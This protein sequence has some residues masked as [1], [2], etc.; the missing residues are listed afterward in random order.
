MIITSTTTVD[1]NHLNAFI[2][3]CKEYDREPGEET[4]H[5]GTGDLEGTT[6]SV[7]RISTLQGNGLLVTVGNDDEVFLVCRLIA[8]PV[9]QGALPWL[10]L[11]HI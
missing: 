11:I 7:K 2:A 8:A 6:I 1:N 4:K 3:D 10:S 5:W 9:P